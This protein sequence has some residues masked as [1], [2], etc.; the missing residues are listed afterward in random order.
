MKKLTQ[1]L[2]IRSTNLISR[3]IKDTNTLNYIDLITYKS[4][5]GVYG[6]SNL[7][8]LII[9]KL[10][11]IIKKSQ[12]S[13]GHQISISCIANSNIY[14][15]SG[16]TNKFQKEIFNISN[17]LC[18]Q[19]TC[20]ESAISLLMYNGISYKDFPYYFY[21]ISKKFRNEIRPRNKIIRCL[22]FDMKDGY[23]FHISQDCANEFYLKIKNS[24]INIFKYLDIEV[25]ILNSDTESMLATNSEEFI[26]KSNDIIE[27]KENK[28]YGIE[29]AHIFKLGC[30]YSNKLNIFCTSKFN[31]LKPIF[32]NSYG[33]GIYRLLY[34]Y[35][36]KLININIKQHLLI[37]NICLIGKKIIHEYQ[38]LNINN[39]V[40]EFDMDN[41]S[42][43]EKIFFSK[44]LPIR[45]IMLYESK[46]ILV[47]VRDIANFI[48]YVFEESNNLIN[49]IN[50]KL[51]L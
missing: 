26:Y 48:Y 42:V 22:E 16:R 49:L 2:S 33:I 44:Y 46:T 41:L 18:L 31:N 27:T 19:P 25:E 9:E 40:I 12:D 32:M 38:K 20:E 30:N 51:D 11:N 10:I 21:Q 45:K 4:T 29:I 8:I 5:S 34:I 13:F 7:G 37:F 47:I 14:I 43:E 24:Y 15:K 23:S 36:N 39:N 17:K 28:F 35:I 6:F 1:L 3:F 50:L